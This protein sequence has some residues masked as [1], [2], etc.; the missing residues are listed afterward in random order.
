MA[1]LK[2]S[3]TPPF[4]DCG[5][6]TVFTGASFTGLI[7]M[8]SVATFELSEPSLALKVKLSEPL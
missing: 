6:G 1:T 3:A 7:V 2:T 5:P 8:L 4:A